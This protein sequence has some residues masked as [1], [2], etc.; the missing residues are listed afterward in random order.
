MDAY[1]RASWGS[2]SRYGTVHIPNDPYG[3]RGLPEYVVDAYPNVHPQPI[4]YIIQSARPEDVEFFLKKVNQ[5]LLLTFAE[6]TEVLTYL[7]QG[8]SVAVNGNDLIPK[9]LRELVLLAISVGS[10]E[11]IVHI[12]GHWEPEPYNVIE[13]DT[14][15]DDKQ[16]FAE[17]EH[18]LAS[19]L[20]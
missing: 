5:K 15:G 8:K 17:L 18:K 20:V 4:L 16:F 19:S 11:M 2:L 14:D 10:R 3:R 12:K 9:Q 13:Y 7:E 1:I 6:V